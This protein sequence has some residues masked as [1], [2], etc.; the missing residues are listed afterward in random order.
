MHSN[1]PSSRIRT[2]AKEAAAP[3]GPRSK[4]YDRP[5][6]HPKDGRGC[7]IAPQ[8]RERAAERAAWEDHTGRRMTARQ[9]KKERRRKLAG[10]VSSLFNR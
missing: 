6:S 8:R 10:K 4:K 9:A 3:K 1:D 2:M 7:A 5:S